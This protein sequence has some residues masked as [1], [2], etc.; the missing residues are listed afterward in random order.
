MAEVVTAAVISS[1]VEKL[2]TILQDEMAWLMMDVANETEKLSST[3]SSIRAV[4]EDVE[5]RR[6]EDEAVKQWL[7]DLKDVAYDVDD[8]L[9]ER[10]TEALKLQAADEDSGYCFS[11]KKVR[12]FL[13]SVNC[14][15]HVALRH[16]IGSRIKEVR[17]R[18]DDI[19]R[20]RSQIMGLR[21]LD[22][23]E[24]ERVE[25]EVRWGEIREREIGSRL[26]RPLVVGR[27]DD[28]NEV[29]DLLLNESSGEVNEVPLVIS[30]VGMGGLGKTT[31]AQ[32]AYNDE[33]IKGHFEMRMWVRVSEDFDVKRITKSIIQ[34]ATETGCESFDL[35]QLQDCLGKMLHE[36]RFLLVL[37]D[38]WS[39]DREKWD[40]LRLPFQN[41][42]LG[43]RIVITTRSENVASAM[44][45]AHI[46]KLAVLSDDDCWLLFSHIALE[47]RSAEERSELEEIGRII[48]KKCGGLPLAAKTIGS[49]LCS[50]RTRSEWELVLQ[51]DIWNSPDALQGLPALLLSYYDLPPALKQCFAYFSIFPKDLEIEKDTIVKLWVA[52]GFIP[53]DTG[54]DVEEIGG[55]YIDDLLRRSL[56]QDV[57][58]DYDNYICK[59]KM[60]GLV[61]D[62]AQSVARRHCSLV[63]I[64]M[65]TFF[66]PSYNRHS[67][68]IASDEAGEVDP[69]WATLYQARK[70]RTLLR[71]SRISRVPQD[72]F[73]HFRFLRALDLSRTDMKILPRTVEKWKHLR[74]V[75]LSYT[76]IEVLP[77]GLSNCINLQTLRL[78][79]CQRLRKLPKWISTMISLRHLEFQSHVTVD[80][81][82]HISYLPQRITTL[83]GL[84]TLTDFIVSGGDKGYK[85]GD[86]KHFKHLGGRLQIIGLENVSRD[87]AREAELDKKQN[88]HTLS[89]QY[90]YRH[91][92]LFHDEVKTTEDVLESLQPH[93]NLKVLYIWCYQGFKLPKWTED[94]V[95]SNL[96]KVEL[97]HCRKCKQLPS[98]G[99]LPSLKFLK[100]VGMTEVTTVGSEF[101]NNDGS[102]GG[103]S[104]PKLQILIFS[105]MPNWE[106]W[107]LS[108]GDGEVM[109]SLLELEINDCGKL[110]ALP[111]NLPPL[112]RKLTLDISN[113]GMSSGGP[114]PLLHEL[115][116]L[117]IRRSPDLTSLPCGWLG[118]LKSLQTLE[119]HRC[120]RL[121]SL[122]RP[123]ELQHLT[124]LQEL[125][126]SFCPLLEKRCQNGGEYH[127]K[128]AR[129]RNLSIG[130]PSYSALG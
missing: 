79:F 40:K 128:I 52:Q 45:S 88:L 78:N 43:S 29:L 24:G 58:L 118:K 68:L 64:R 15:K 108:C 90:D 76:D 62:L 119:I 95:F 42:A 18:L 1:G 92:E 91:G 13:S 103:V 46:H 41:G 71:D 100:I 127:D 73:D 31:L 65:Q 104:F 109:P 28:K 35:D 105:N 102:G 49:V 5:T 69:I 7:Q 99:K 39:E 117:V 34:S 75:D 83:T 20:G 121:R 56:L 72:L 110:K 84:R 93:T 63:G 12:R 116:H 126:I 111:Y 8:I 32:L 94:P 17:G 51:D 16:K 85:C 3:F 122:S 129:V 60:H 87:E 98:L 82:H 38:V 33:K 70:L 57:E 23:G 112:I 4:I 11:K 107:E 77:D 89:L 130:H 114:F 86:L 14:F 54:R 36:K 21:V 10:R 9:D 55:L 50:R 113:D 125:K 26:D 80:S 66:Y 44:R 25:S 123:E 19:A 2:N 48:V 96:L 27:E 120:P 53:S 74:Y 97:Q 67:F 22:S 124:M 59:C 47:H 6:V 30:I 106:A 115:K 81:A 101:D 37:D 61:H